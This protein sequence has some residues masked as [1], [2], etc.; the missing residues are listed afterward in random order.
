MKHIRKIICTL[1]IALLMLGIL[2]TLG[3]TNNFHGI[4]KKDTLV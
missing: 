2:I 1:I 3:M 4:G